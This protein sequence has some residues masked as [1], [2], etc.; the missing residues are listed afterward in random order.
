MASS[1]ETP[2]ANG[3]VEFRTL[4]PSLHLCT[5]CKSISFPDLA[6]GDRSNPIPH[7]ATL[8]KLQQSADEGCA[9]CQL[10]WSSIVTNYRVTK[11]TAKLFTEA[12]SELSLTVSFEGTWG[13][14]WLFLKV[15]KG[16]DLVVVSKLEGRGR[17]ERDWTRDLEARKI[18]RELAAGIPSFPDWRHTYTYPR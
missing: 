10:A 13:E 12:L 17:V 16:D 4:D 1:G 8:D 5:H 15:E 3:V 6:R 18:K 9:M 2:H 11:A 14:G 7:H